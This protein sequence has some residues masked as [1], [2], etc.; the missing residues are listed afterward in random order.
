MRMRG[1]QDPHPRPPFSRPFAS[2]FAGGEGTRRPT[3]GLARG[4][5]H[6]L[7]EARVGRAVPAR[8][9]RGCGWRWMARADAGAGRAASAPALLAPV[10]VP[11]AGGE[12][13]RR[14]TRG[15][16]RGKAL[17]M[18]AARVGRAV[19]ARQRMGC[20]RGWMA[21]ADA[22]RGRWARIRARPSRPRSRPLRW[23]RRDSPPY[24]RASAWKSAFHARSAGRASTPCEPV[25]ECGRGKRG[26]LGELDPGALRAQ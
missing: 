9:R 11:V 16:A 2:P 5:A 13:T 21:R 23:R 12:G 25:G 18:R 7:R 4:K 24:P 6:P 22:G 1:G 17:P 10:C 8:Q 19:P 26:S 14:P 20:G 15:L 3:H